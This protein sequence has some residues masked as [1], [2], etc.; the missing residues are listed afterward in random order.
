MSPYCAL[1]LVAGT[2]GYSIIKEARV[3]PY[4][5][6]GVLVKIKRPKGTPTPI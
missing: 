2:G 6:P 4:P 1:G 3:S 5:P